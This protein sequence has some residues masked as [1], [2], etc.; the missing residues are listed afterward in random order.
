[1]DEV[2]I[3]EIRIGKGN[4][5]VLIAGPCVLEGEA[6][7]LEIAKKLKELCGTLKIPL[8]FKASYE[9]DNRGSEKSYKGPGLEEG[10]RVLAKVKE[11][12]GIPVSPMCT[13]WRMWIGLR[14]FSMSFKSLPFSVSRRAFFL[15]WER[16]GEWSTLRRG[17]SSLQKKWQEQL[18]RST[19]PEI[20]RSF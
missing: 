1:M 12:V 18:K 13:G 2:K 19:A 15:K 9:K 11:K 7:A 8:I 4:P 5:L 10:L 17:N 20:A 14:R 3:G 16:Q 6:M